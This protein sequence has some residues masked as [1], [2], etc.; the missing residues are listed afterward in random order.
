MARS[1]QQTHSVDSKPG[2]K[3]PNTCV[4]T[5]K[6]LWCC[7]HFLDMGINPCLLLKNGNMFPMVKHQQQYLL[8]AGVVA[9]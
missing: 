3:G 2:L 4:T 8:D 1:A 6:D 5:A 7:R 9:F